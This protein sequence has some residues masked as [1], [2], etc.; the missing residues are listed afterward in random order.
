MPAS[1]SLVSIQDA[2]T[3]YVVARASHIR[4]L[5]MRGLLDQAEDVIHNG[6]VRCITLFF[7]PYL[8]LMY[9][10]ANAVFATV[11]HDM[12]TN[13]NRGDFGRLRNS[14]PRFVAVSIQI[15]ILGVGIRILGRVVRTFF[16][17]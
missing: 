16:F 2:V 13:L 9:F 10:S 1:S 17:E 12:R 7:C 14:I 6:A 11:A 15:Y 3:G 4:R 8:L 5:V